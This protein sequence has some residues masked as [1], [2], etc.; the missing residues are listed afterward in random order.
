MADAL[1]GHLE[2]YLERTLPAGYAHR[3]SR[4]TVA[5]AAALDAVAES[6]PSIARSIL[7]EL[8]DQRQHLKLIAGEN[9]TS[10]SVLLSMGNW[11]NDKS[12]EGVPGKRLYAGCDNVDDIE[13]YAVDSARRLFG[14]EHAYVQ[15]HSGL[16]AN[17]VAFWAVLSHRVEEPLL[18]RR[19]LRRVEDMAAP[20]WAELR[21]VLGDQRILSMSLEA[22]GHLS[23][24]LRGNLT[25]KLFDVHTYGVD[26]STHRVDYAA[27]AQAAREV[28]P[29]ILVAGYSA[30]PR[31]INLRIFREIAD[32]VGATLMVDMAHVA[33]LV[34]GGALTGDLNPVPFADIVTTTTHKTLRGPRGGL[35]LSTAQLAPF[36]DRGCPLVISAPIP[37][38][39]AAKAVAL[40]QASTPMFKNYA[41][42][43]VKNARKLAETLIAHGVR[44]LTGGTDNHLVVIDVR[45]F[46]LTG[47]QAES[48]LREC[49]LTCNR[50][51]LP[52][53]SHGRW[54][55]GGLRLGTPA[56][57]TLGMG[58]AEMSEVGE[59][60]YATLQA[61]KSV[62]GSRSRYHLDPVIRQFV[63]ERALTLL[64]RF[65]LY[66]DIEL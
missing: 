18:D 53:D 58:T 33:G 64:G 52:D 36:V 7:A 54:Y 45:P 3:I 46:D 16:D 34:A 19:G 24:G 32:E 57:T 2:N 44:V 47:R 63:S 21:Q 29:L 48:A 17:L 35:V 65:P 41:R 28:R 13:S 5:F 55:T 27:V 61:T 12:A 39:M 56:L 9:F 8:T 43:V 4:D 31:A 10:P 1:G 60:V 25:G 22:G 14:A 49:R 62:T 20:D 50:N 40:D 66:P 15:P 38:M 26:P 23:H 37:Q 51:V 42:Q 11:L 30:Y 6:S 59:L